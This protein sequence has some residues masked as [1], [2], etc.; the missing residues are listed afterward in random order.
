MAHV[1]MSTVVHA[2]ANTLWDEIGAFE[3]VGAWH[4]LLDRVEV[5]GRRRIAYDKNGIRHV[6][7]LQE[8]YSRKR[9]Y[10]YTIDESPMPIRNYTAEL[11]VDDNQDGTSTVRWSGDFDVAD[12][13]RDKTVAIIETFFKA[14]LTSL[15]GRHG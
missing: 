2:D 3:R 11:R 15:R 14:G 9:R 4:P 8:S 13:E 5:E 1:E 7:T 6:E 10:R 12:Q